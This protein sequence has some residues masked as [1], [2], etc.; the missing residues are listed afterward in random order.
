MLPYFLPDGALDMNGIIVCQW[1]CEFHKPDK[2]QV[3]KFGRFMLENLQF[4]K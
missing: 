2:K 3:E 1:T 4:G